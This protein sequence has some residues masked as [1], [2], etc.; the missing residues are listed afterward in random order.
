MFRKYLAYYPNRL[1]GILRYGQHYTVKKCDFTLKKVQMFSVQ[2]GEIWKP[3]TISGHIG[4]VLGEYSGGNITWLSVWRH[5]FRKLPRF[6]SSSLN[7]KPPFSNSSAPSTVKL[8]FQISPEY[9]ERCQTV[10]HSWRILSFS[11]VKDGEGKTPK[12]R[13]PPAPDSSYPVAVCV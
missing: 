4:F 7:S 1:H 8:S 13:R 6:L 10:K 9:S 2:T 3:A 11:C 5:R 12:T